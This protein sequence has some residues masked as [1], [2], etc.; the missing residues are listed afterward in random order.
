MDKQIIDQQRLA[1]IRKFNVN[2]LQQTL[3]KI[4]EFQVPR[5]TLFQD[6]ITHATNLSKEEY[7]R[8]SDIVVINNQLHILELFCLFWKDESKYLFKLKTRTKDQIPTGQDNITKWLIPYIKIH[9]IESE[10]TSTEPSS[11]IKRT[12]M[13]MITLITRKLQ[14]DHRNLTYGS[15]A[16]N[17]LGKNIPFGDIDFFSLGAYRFMIVLLI[18]CKVGFNCPAAIVGVPYIPGHLS[19]RLKDGTSSLVICD[20]FHLQK[21]ALKFI[22]TLKVNDLYIIDPEQEIIKL[23]MSVT[24]RSITNVNKYIDRIKT[25][26]PFYKS[27]SKCP[28]IKNTTNLSESLYNLLSSELILVKLAD[29]FP[30]FVLK[31]P[32]KKQIPL[33]RLGEYITK[34]I[35]NIKFGPN[36]T[37]RKSRDF[38]TFFTPYVYEC[39]NEKDQFLCFIIA[40]LSYDLPIDAETKLSSI[41]LN[42]LISCNLF[43]YCSLYQF[44]GESDNLVDYKG[45]CDL[46]KYS[47]KYFVESIREKSNEFII[48][49][50]KPGGPHLHID[51]E[52]GSF[53]NLITPPQIVPHYSVV[54]P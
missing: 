11:L 3:S 16:I 18:I 54:Y 25:L 19:L 4:L 33:F 28:I 14:N 6:I 21:S 27:I 5:I 48:K 12:K 1:F 24:Q 32:E 53:N 45:L 41:R 50:Y 51:I 31:P 8:I 44:G 15:F 30:V 38:G 43:I 7:P 23:I 26:A 39:F 49:R 46:L 2:Q 10:I 20:C 37:I 29:D 35:K 36:I 9:Q 52:T 17:Q 13:Y 40:P 34:Q 42:I 22:K 47:I